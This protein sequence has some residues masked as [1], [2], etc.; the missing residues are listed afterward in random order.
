MAQMHAEMN[1]ALDELI[2]TINA[3]EGDLQEELKNLDADYARRTNSHTKTVN[4]LTLSIGTAEIDVASSQD[5]IDNYLEPNVEQTEARIEQIR[6]NIESNRATLQKETVLRNNEHDSFVERV[7]EH[8]E[9]I[10]SIDSALQIITQ[11][12]N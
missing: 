5:S 1:G 10:D 3:L 6:E 11:L 2:E 12:L 9:S 4:E 8:Q 7:K